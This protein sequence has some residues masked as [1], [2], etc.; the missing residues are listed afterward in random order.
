MADL[1]SEQRRRL[2]E[3]ADELAG[4]NPRLARALAGRGYALRQRRRTRSSRRDRRGSVLAC[5]AVTLLL[6]ALPLLSLGMLLP[7]P[8]LIVLGAWAMLN[9]P[10]LFIAATLQ[11]PAR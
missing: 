1:T 9:G 7:Q 11:R 6:A 2:D 8:V 10:M 4:D 3:L 5:L